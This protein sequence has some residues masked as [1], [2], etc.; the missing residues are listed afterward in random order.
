MKICGLPYSVFLRNS[1]FCSVF[2]LNAEKIKFRENLHNSVVHYFH[3]PYLFCIFWRN[4]VKNTER[5]Q[6]NPVISVRN[7]SKILMEFRFR[8]ELSL[9]FRYNTR[10][11]TM[12]V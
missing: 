9:D 5:K 6:W 3:I 4:S 7:F 1:V 2:R 8:T 10:I 12:E 11:N